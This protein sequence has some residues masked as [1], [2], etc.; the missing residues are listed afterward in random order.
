MSP[1][2]ALIGR[3]NVGKSTLFNRMIRKRRTYDKPT[4]ITEETPGVTRDRN[5]GP[6][7]WEDRE[8]TVVDT[9]GLYGEH[10]PLDDSEIS[11][12]VKE[13][14][15][16]AIEEA[17][18]VIHLL[19][20]KSG[21]APAD[22]DL[23]KFLR[24]TGKKVLWV[25]NKID[26]D[27]HAE[28]VIDFYPLGLDEIIPLSALSGYGF[29]EFMDRVCS[30]LPSREP[31]G[32]TAEEENAPIPKVAVVGRPNV[33]KSTLINS[34]LSRKRLVVT[35]T[36]GTTRDAIDTICTFYRKPYLFIDTAGIRK[37]VPSH[38]VEGFSVM[39]SLR[40]IERADIALIVLDA[41]S[42]I[43]DQDQKIAGI[44]EESGKGAIFLLNKWDTVAD[45]EREF[46]RLVKEL[47]RR[48]WFLEFAPCITISGLEKKRVTKVFPLI[49][50]IV[51]QRRKRVPTGELN[52]FLAKVTA[53]K[54]IPLFR[55]REVKFFY[56]TQT[57]IEPPAFTIFVNYPSAL[58]QN[59][60][61]YIEKAL[62][63]EYSFGG[64]P[65]R[66]YFKSR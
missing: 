2:V 45:P 27:Q 62:R 43:V 49:D 21:L 66:I 23:V 6:V 50:E 11:R 48:M 26:A 53:L 52:R 20:G 30:S 63:D 16:A 54:R 35:S 51:D 34:L 18:V 3:P 37:R 32:P 47:R 13:Q 44:V 12:Q 40:S 17:D 64:T 22:T 33:G 58:R 7:E 38:S 56:M 41:E 46:K 55:G 28:R 61:R 42:G 15:L 8:F 25:V 9:G 29:D 1:I 39:R 36:P 19:D 65:I 31:Y 60:G 4:A 14:A 59:H 10:R 24:K 5:Y 57:G